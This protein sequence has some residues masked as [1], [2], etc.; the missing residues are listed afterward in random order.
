[1]KSVDKCP[2]CSNFRDLPSHLYE[3]A[4]F[5]RFLDNRNEYERHDVKRMVETKVIS[6]WLKLAAELEVVKINSWKFGDDNA[7]M[8]C[9]PIADEYDSNSKHYTAYSTAL[10]RFIFVSNA[11]EELYRFVDGY[12]L[13]I[14][15][16]AKLDERKKLRD[17]S[18]RATVLVD[19][20]KSSEL[21]L[22]FEHSISNLTATFDYYQ[23]IFKPSLSGMKGAKVTDHSYGL[24]L[25][26]NLRNYVAHGIFPIL[27]NPEYWSGTEISRNKLIS[28]LFHACRASSLYIQALLFKYNAGFLLD[29]YAQVASMSWEDGY[30]EYF[31]KNCTID[32][33]LNLHTKVQFTFE[34][35]FGYKC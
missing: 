25:V 26:R 35:P 22:N 2:I 8:Y 12:Y 14:P 21:P 19:E 31:V 24:H 9:R 27:D 23:S 15:S 11:L 3:L 17:A 34:N 5:C 7:A 18:L 1:M 16:I 4:E 32:L 13:L 33:A 30:E 29:D 20:L 6:D 28:L 10:T